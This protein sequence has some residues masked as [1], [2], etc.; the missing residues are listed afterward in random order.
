MT[1]DT[2]AG[3]ATSYY[4]E[5]RAAQRER[6]LAPAPGESARD[7]VSDLAVASAALHERWAALNDGEW[8]TPV[9]EPRDNP[10]L[11][12]IEL[13]RL[14]LLRLTEVEVHGCDLAIGLPDW[15]D[16]FVA[17][18]LPARV[19]WLNTRRSNHRKVDLGITGTWRLASTEGDTWR[20]TAQADGSVQA[21][22]GD[23]SAEATISASARDLLATLLGRPT[24]GAITYRG[25]VELAKAFSRAFPGP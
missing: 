1:A 10:D 5:G 24:V 14:P 20:V 3:R 22:E 25:D 8:S 11:G 18:A 21:V 15:S 12:P 9:R 19:A 23:G 2:C 4:P 17:A 13:S 6:T 7:V 16:A